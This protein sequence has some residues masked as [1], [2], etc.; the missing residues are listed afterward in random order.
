MDK[1]LANYFIEEA[2]KA[3]AFVVNEHSFAAPQVELLDKINFVFVIFMGH[4]IAIE[5]SL[6]ER[7]GDIT[8][9]IARVIDGKRAT[10]RDAIDERDEQGMR[11]RENLSQYLRR[12]GVRGRILTKIEGLDFHERIKA[13]LKDFAQMLK[14]HGRAVLEDSPKALR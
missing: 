12:Q 10:Y 6:D 13:T 3:F 11:V 8:C 2:S 7:E 4:N 5:C 14:R 9:I 1:Q